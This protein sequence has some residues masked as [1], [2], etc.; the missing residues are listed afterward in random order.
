M[1]AEEIVN[2]II[3]FYVWCG[4]SITILIYPTT[5]LWI[6]IRFKTLNFAA[7]HKSL[8]LQKISRLYIQIC[9]L[10]SI[11][12]RIIGFQIINLL[13]ITVFNVTFVTFEAYDIIKENDEKKFGYLIFIAS[14]NFHF[15]LLIILT[16]AT[17]WLMVKEGK[18]IEEI[19]HKK[20]YHGNL[21]KLKRIQILQQQIEHCQPEVSLGFFTL[22][23][24]IMHS[25]SFCCPI[26]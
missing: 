24:K 11:F 13:G 12:T 17:N 3:S 23:W 19:L 9:E 5:F 16:F 25:V 7:K 1:D 4:G 10:I 14:I 18:K 8:S 20:T 2:G 6:K 15:F 26:F 21:I 22:D